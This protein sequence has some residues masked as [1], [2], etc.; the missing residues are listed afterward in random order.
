VLG[1]ELAHFLEHNKLYVL[2]PYPASGVLKT[3]S[4]LTKLFI[5]KNRPVP[6]TREQYRAIRE[7]T[8]A[9]YE[10]HENFEICF[11]DEIPKESIFIQDRH[12]MFYA[13]IKDELIPY[14]SSNAALVKNIYKE[15]HDP[16]M[17]KIS[18]ATRADT[19][20]RLRELIASI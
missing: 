12:L 5:S 8:L 10:T 1:T 19:A 11:S 4:P 3:D 6:L 20:N 16:F 2:L 17:N 15:T 7:Q 13:R 18:C 14:Q 9:L